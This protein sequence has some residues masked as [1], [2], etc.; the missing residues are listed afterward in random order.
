MK[1][2]SLI[3]SVSL[4]LGTAALAQDSEDSF[5]PN[6]VELGCSARTAIHCRNTASHECQARAQSIC[7]MHI[8]R[9]AVLIGDGTC[10]RVGARNWVYH[11]RYKCI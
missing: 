3:L 9:G 10:R 5:D 1:R 7:T 11:A 4:F 6:N 2:F 8:Y